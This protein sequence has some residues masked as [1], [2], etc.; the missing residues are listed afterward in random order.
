MSSTTNTDT[1]IIGGGIIGVSIASQLVDRDVTILD[2][3][4]PKYGTSIGNAGHVV[5]SHAQ[6]FAAPGMIG[7]GAKSLLAADGAF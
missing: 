2:S 4:A 7:M 6:P 3:G 1:L 5:V